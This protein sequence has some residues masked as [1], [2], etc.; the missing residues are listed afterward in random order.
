MLF[1]APKEK[2]SEFI[3]R[4]N[5]VKEGLRIIADFEREDRHNGCFSK[6]YYTI[7]NDDGEIVLQ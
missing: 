7:V 4:T 6:N 1:I 5:N 2:P 3:V